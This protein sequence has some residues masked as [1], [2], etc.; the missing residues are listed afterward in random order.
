MANIIDSL[1]IELGL[2]ISKF[3][4]SQQDVI[5][6]LKEIEKTNDDVSKSEIDN[7]QKVISVKKK[8][9]EEDK[10]ISV[11]KKKS[12]QETV[13]RTKEI[14]KD[15]KEI[16]DS[17][18]KTITSI[19]T[20]GASLA[21][22]KE[23]SDFSTKLSLTNAALGRTSEMLGLKPEVVSAWSGVFEK[24]GDAAG[25]FSNTLGSLLSRISQV[26]SGGSLLSDIAMQRANPSFISPFEKDPSKMFDLLKFAQELKRLEGLYGKTH[27]LNFAQSMGFTSQEALILLN[28]TIEELNKLYKASLD[29]VNVN[30]DITEAAKKT[31]EE[32]VTLDQKYTAL[33]N[34]VQETLGPKMTWWRNL[35]GEIIDNF[36]SLDKTSRDF[37]VGLGLIGGGLAS[38][39]GFAGLLSVLIPPLAPI[40]A[41][42]AMGAGV[43]A[44]G[45]TAM[46]GGVWA[47]GNTS[48]SNNNNNNNNNNAQSLMNYYISKGLDKEHAAALVGNAMHESA[49]VNPNQSEIGNTGEGYGIFQWG[50]ER[51]KDFQNKYGK[52]IKGSSLEE[53]ADFSLSELQTGHEKKAGSHFFSSTG[54]EKLSQLISD[55]YLRPNRLFAHNLDRAVYTNMALRDYTGAHVNTPTNNTA[56]TDNS[57]THINTTINSN[58]T[59]GSGLAE[60][61]LGRMSWTSWATSTF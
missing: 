42:I 10:K 2:D 15:N 35:Q 47:H 40:L 53:Q 30:H 1:S 54:A 16:A 61:F 21:G 38:L 8:A 3:K 6:G 49:G 9:A 24:G 55:E 23:L 14:I 60:D 37:A 28:N 26:K 18:N 33:G 39:S 46:A 11:E 31:Q 44:L 7:A 50:T 41:P 52:S 22:I 56:H 25:A 5:A 36:R 12:D 48:K 19:A 43:G 20:F 45:A 13:K 29:Q 59:D 4:K 32:I 17:F 51:Q 27:A 34:T 58:A 57:Q